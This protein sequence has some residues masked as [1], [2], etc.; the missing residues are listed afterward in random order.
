[1]EFCSTKDCIVIIEDIGK[2]VKKKIENF[3]TKLWITGS[4]VDNW[5]D[6]QK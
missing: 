5:L 2:G 4:P 6:E 1:M 3:A